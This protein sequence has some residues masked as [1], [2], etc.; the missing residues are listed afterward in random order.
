LGFARFHSLL[1][2]NRGGTP[3]ANYTLAGTVAY[4]DRSF[5][6]I[7][8]HALGL[9]GVRGK[10]F[11]DRDG[12]GELGPDEAPAP[13]VEVTAG[14]QRGQTDE[15]GE[16]RIWG[17]S[18]YEPIVVQMDTVR[19]FVPDW[20]PARTS[21]VLRTV[22]NLYR[23]VDIPL[24]LTKEILGA[25]SAGPGVLTVGGVT[26][27][28]E[29]LTTG[30]VEEVLTFSDGTFYVPRIR[31]G[32]YRLRPSPASLE[33]LDA[34]ASPDFLEFRVDADEERPF[35]ELPPLRLERRVP[36]DWPEYGPGN[37]NGPAALVDEWARQTRP[38]RSGGG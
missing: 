17:V 34:V 5:S 14:H 25:V 4:Q 11:L 38:G 28:L 12:D 31:V 32:R 23:D 24:A 18:P 2:S 30:D 3:R 7:P 36:G 22:P 10:V 27:H 35:L 20:A 19:S 26:L 9:S 37:G 21:V 15:R 33:A 1:R 13:F 16:Y 6:V 29:N 8:D